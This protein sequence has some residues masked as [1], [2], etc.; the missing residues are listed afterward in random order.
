M[1]GVHQ[2]TI[3]EVEDV[4]WLSVCTYLVFFMQTGFAFLEGGVI[5]FKNVQNILLKNL[6]D[7]IFGSIVWWVCGYAFAFGGDNS[8]FIGGDKYY[9][10]MS[11]FLQI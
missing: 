7:V 2:T 5:R 11:S 8:G 9:V 10:G 1:A 6:L 4:I 3:Y